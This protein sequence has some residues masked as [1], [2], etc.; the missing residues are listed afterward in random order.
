[1]DMFIVLHCCLFPM[2]HDSGNTRLGYSETLCYITQSVDIYISFLKSKYSEILLNKNN[3]CLFSYIYI[4]I[5]ISYIYIYNID[6]LNELNISTF[7]FSTLYTD[8]SYYIVLYTKL[9]NIY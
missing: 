2:S 8:T 4:I 3:K 7:G 9:L 5:Y 1:M 6:A